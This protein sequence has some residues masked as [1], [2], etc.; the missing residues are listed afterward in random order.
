MK[1]YQEQTQLHLPHISRVI[2]DFWEENKIFERSVAQRENQEPFVFFEGPPSANGAPGAHHILA[3]TVKDLFTRY[4][5]M[6]GYYVRRKSGWD[7]HGLPV[8]LQVEKKLGI[9]K[10]DIGKKISI[11]DYNQQCRETVMAYTSEW[12]E[13]NQALGYWKDNGDPYVTY[14]RNYI[15]SV[16]YLIKALYNK[17]LIYK[18]Y[19]VQPYSPAA[20][21][22][23]SSH[24]LNQPGC[25]K[26]IK[27]I[28]VV[29]QFKLKDKENEYFLAWT[30]T[31]WTLPANSALAVGASIQYVKIATINPY[32]HLPIQV[33]L[34][35]DAVERFFIGTQTIFD[36]HKSNNQEN[37][38]SLPW[39]IIA[40]YT[41][42]ALVGLRYEQLLPYV[43]PKGDA[44]KVIAGDF[45]TTTDGTG[46]VH[47]APTFGADDYR[48]AQKENISAVMVTNTEGEE[49][50][51]VDKQGRFVPEITD[52][53]G[54]YVKKEYESDI[55]LPA[56]DVLIVTKL[57]QENK[58][59]KVEK[60]E[61]NYPHCWRT[62]KPILYYPLDSWF[63]KTTLYKELL[64]ELNN[65]I[66]WKPVSVGK[67]RFGNWLE[68][69]VDWN[70][71]RERYW[72]TPLPIWR[73]VDQQEEKCISSIA[74]LMFEAE[75]A[76]LA[77]Y[78]KHP[79]PADI[80]LHRPY[81]D[82]IVLVS[83]SGLP[84]YRET[85]VIDVWFDSG[86]MPCAQWHYP[87][88][89]QE[90]FEKSFPADFIA[91]G[92]DQTRGWF[93]TLHAISTMLFETPAFKNVVVNGLVLDKNGNKMSKSIG[94]TINPMEILEK[95]GPDAIRWYMMSNA[96]PWDN[97]KFDLAG[98]EEATR[99][100]FI[101]LNSTYNFF[102]LYANL[103]HFYFKSVRLHSS[104]LSQSDRWIV[105]RCN[106]LIKAVT[107]FYD[108]YEPTLVARAIQDFVVDDLSN[109]YVR[110]N[111]KRFWKNSQDKDK[112]AAYQTLYS[113]LIVVG[114]LMAPIA[115]FYADYLYQSLNSITGKEIHSSVH[116]SDFP[117]VEED[118]LDIALENQMSQVQTIVSLAHALR[119]KYKI[120]VRQPLQTLSICGTCSTDVTYL[121]NLEALI[122]AEINV[123]K[124][125]YLDGTNNLVHKKAKADFSI[126]GKRYK[127][128]M[129]LLSEAIL[130]LKQDE[131]AALEVGHTHLLCIEGESIALNLSDVLIITEDIPGWCV[132]TEGTI[133]IALDTS[134]NSALQE[135][136]VAREVI[137]RIQQLRK[138]LSFEV[139]DKIVI[140]IQED[141]KNICSAIFLYRDYIC[142]ETQAVLLKFMP[143]LIGG[144]IIHIDDSALTIRL[145]KEG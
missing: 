95:Y 19:S 48:I 114:K 16:W 10:E 140:E 139:Q 121:S 67:G 37:K 14:D 78:M 45:V 51:I 22:G 47:I 98:V 40:H 125:D 44:F 31:P 27:D 108:N 1:K 46:I 69:L 89:N 135:E 90:I 8:E 103:D 73:T 79:L 104:E 7:T 136:G 87:F 118:C 126:L 97:L 6:Q 129:K 85:A 55:N 127:N 134:I 34:A 23:L 101:T 54:R 32:T 111:R 145:T 124:I 81:V 131:I 4:K 12:Q 80:D 3:M 70:L 20:G 92:I 33:I 13:M 77:G 71:S 120:K 56:V 38:T 110:L 75:Q 116:L 9:T 141:A 43:L 28:S 63:I 57:K 128:K 42:A 26:L 59:F 96:N 105:S 72:G 115:P 132:A 109:W 35:K 5:T 138:E 24:E 61:H 18:G 93:F 17:G 60:Y 107:N 133:T 119:K 49:V 84:M 94:N 100:V 25:Y 11:I 50:P 53:A 30:T 106:T 74:E 29:A 99:K 68:N 88:E 143:Q 82:D 137:H 112:E 91:E 15:E 65:T 52:F 62:N 113:C 36:T 86:A 39:E 2:R 117:L 41:G 21:T 64:V 142:A 83:N 66:Q 123:K 102:V 144:S 130:A 122:K 58:A 76:V